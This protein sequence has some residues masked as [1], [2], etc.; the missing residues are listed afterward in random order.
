MSSLY[1]TR[2]R[3]RTWYRRVVLG[4]LAV[5]MLAGGL[6][7]PAGASGVAHAATVYGYNDNG[8]TEK[9]PLTFYNA[10]SS[11]SLFVQ[12]H[13]R[14]YL[15]FWGNAWNSDTATMNTIVNTLKALG[16]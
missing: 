1:Q 13:P 9:P 10:T 5:V 6:F 8:H 15:I 14:L 16:G 3:G 4:I 7:G 11:S 2:L 12:H